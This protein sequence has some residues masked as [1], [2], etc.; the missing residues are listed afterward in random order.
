MD[1]SP[2]YLERAQQ[3]LINTHHCTSV[4][5]FT[6][7]IGRGEQGDELS[8][9]E[10]FV[11][12]FNDLVSTTYEVHVMLLQKSRDNIRAECERDTTVIFTPASDILIRVG[13][14]EIAE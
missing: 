3:A 4:I 11:T 1:K 10:E 5:K 7:V 12:V 14:K 8:L 13:P 2:T 6:T 9:G